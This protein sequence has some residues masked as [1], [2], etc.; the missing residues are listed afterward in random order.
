MPYAIPDFPDDATIEEWTVVAEGAHGQIRRV[1]TRRDGKEVIACFKLFREEW[2]DAYERERDA[3]ALL[4][5][6][7]VKRCIPQIYFKREW[8]RWKWDGN[9][10]TFDYDDRDEILY[11]LVMEYFDEYQQINMQKADI[12]MA[13]ILG[14]TLEMIHNAGV[15]HG[16]IDE[17]NILLVREGGTARIVWIDFSCAWAGKVYRGTGPIEWDMFR[18]FLLETMVRVLQF[19]TLTSEPPY[20]HIRYF[21]GKVSKK[22][23]RTNS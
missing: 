2:K 3:Y 23:S 7:G 22:V 13:E 4:V 18:G 21:G 1:R 16:D 19:L 8:P 5:H 17:R 6:R 9:Q 10:P 14:Q 12:H 11:G 15:A 20:P